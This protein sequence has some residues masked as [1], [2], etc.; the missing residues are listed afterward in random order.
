MH[1]ATTEP[2][3]EV[4]VFPPD[5]GSVVAGGSVVGVGGGCRGALGRQCRPPRAVAGTPAVA[6]GCPP[7]GIPPGPG[8]AVCPFEAGAGSPVPGT[9]AV[10]EVRS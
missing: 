4:S 2:P 8:P 9:G 3:A 7:A 1:R 6:G 5:G 10:P